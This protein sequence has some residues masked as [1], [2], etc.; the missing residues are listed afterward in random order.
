MVGKLPQKSVP[1]SE[2]AAPRSTCDHVTAAKSAAAAAASTLLSSCSG[3][4]AANAA[5]GWRGRPVRVSPSAEAL[6]RASL[7]A[8]LC[9]AA[10]GGVDVAVRRGGDV[11]EP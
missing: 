1:S 8:P 6:P 4:S 10:A 3:E 7:T 5:S 11:I 9:L 2:H